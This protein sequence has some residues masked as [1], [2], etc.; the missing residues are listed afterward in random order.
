MNAPFDRRQVT[1][2]RL[3]TLP[4]YSETAGRGFLWSVGLGNGRDLADA[5]VAFMVENDAPTLLGQVAK[6]Q[7]SLGVFGHAE[8]TFWQRIAE[9][10]MTGAS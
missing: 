8:V 6:A 10:A 3:D 9:H 4:F 1:K 2:A 5:C 7:I